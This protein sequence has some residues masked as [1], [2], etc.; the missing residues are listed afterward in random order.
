MFGLFMIRIDFPADH[1]NKTAELCISESTEESLI[2]PYGQI[3]VS[4]YGSSSLLVLYSLI[5]T[6]VLTGQS[7]QGF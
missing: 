3:N 7:W 2:M 6:G 5:Y 1:I 4:N